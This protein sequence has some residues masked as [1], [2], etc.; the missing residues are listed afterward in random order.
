MGN[1]AKEWQIINSHNNSHNVLLR[2][3]RAANVSTDGV[4]TITVTATDS[5]RTKISGS[6]T[7]TVPHDARQ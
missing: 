5:W 4:Y 2:S 3:E 6:V 1:T 7:M